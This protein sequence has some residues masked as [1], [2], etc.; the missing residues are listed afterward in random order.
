[1]SDAL[2]VAIAVVEQ[3]GRYLVGRRSRDLPLGGLWEFPGGKVEAGETPRAAAVR[4]CLEETGLRVRG[5]HCLLV[6][7]QAYS[8][9]TVTLH[10]IA[11]ELC[12]PAEVPQAPFEWIARADLAGLQFPA[13]NR[14]LLQMLVEC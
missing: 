14:P 8:H 1:M 2:I 5:S 11:C 13:G 10:F 6:H 4:E 7:Q 9:A 3:E 12:D